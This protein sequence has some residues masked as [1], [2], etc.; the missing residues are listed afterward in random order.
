MF[1]FKHFYIV[2]L[3]SVFHNNKLTFGGRIHNNYKNNDQQR[4]N[5]SRRPAAAEDCTRR[6][7]PEDCTLRYANR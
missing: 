1:Y 6:L 4:I 2:Y 7:L 3:R 5:T